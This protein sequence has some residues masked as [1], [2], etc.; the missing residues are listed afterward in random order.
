MDVYIQYMVQLSLCTISWR[1]TLMLVMA[2][3]FVLPYQSSLFKRGIVITDPGSYQI[4]EIEL[5][6]EISIFADTG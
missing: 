3:L 4:F 6:L 2:H 5:S 1:R